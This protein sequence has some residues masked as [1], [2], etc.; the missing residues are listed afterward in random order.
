MFGIFKR[1]RSLENKVEMLHILYDGQ[2]KYLH[3]LEEVLSKTLI[4]AKRSLAWMYTRQ[5]HY[6]RRELSQ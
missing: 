4:K 1:V 3:Q 5:T 2:Q 6:Q